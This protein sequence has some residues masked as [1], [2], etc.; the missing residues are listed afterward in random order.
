MVFELERWDEKYI[1][2]VAEYANNP[3]IARNLRN[4][5]PYPYTWEDAKEFVFSCM[6]ND[7]RRQCARAIV[8]EGRA[9]G[10]IGVFLG[11]DVYEKSAELGYWLAEP[12]W[13]KGIMAEAVRRICGIVFDRYGIVRIF[14]EPFASNTGSRRVLEKAGFRL[15]GILEKSV[16]KCGKILDSC[17]YALL[18][19][20][21]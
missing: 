6:Q 10:S 5:F 18:K 13:G 21:R 8:V 17:I 2:D 4:A 9:V 15:E 20:A 12:F 16:F 7:E 19:E 14:A 1:A 3:N 11:S